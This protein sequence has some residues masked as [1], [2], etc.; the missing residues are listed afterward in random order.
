MAVLRASPGLESPRCL[1]RW[2]STR[3]RADETLIHVTLLLAKLFHTFSRT[4]EK[5]DVRPGILANVENSAGFRRWCSP[6]FSWRPLVL[7]NKHNRKQLH[8]RGAVTERWDPDHA[9]DGNKYVG[10]ALGNMIFDGLGLIN[11]SEKRSY[12][13]VFY[14]PRQDLTIHTFLGLVRTSYSLKPNQTSHE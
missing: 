11:V 7:S 5:A 12:S 14:I 6:L 4:I 2:L 10:T 8:S 1:T 3:D 13:Y 9:S